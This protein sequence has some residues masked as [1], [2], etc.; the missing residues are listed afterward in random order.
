MNA[1]SRPHTESKNR[2]QDHV[3]VVAAGTRGRARVL[4]L[5][6]ARAGAD[7]A[8]FGAGRGL[9]AVYSHERLPYVDE[10]E[11][12]IAGVEAIGRRCKAFEA[13]LLDAEQLEDAIAKTV[14][15]YGRLD[16]VVAIAGSLVPVPEAN[17]ERE[18]QDEL[19]LAVPGVFPI[20]KSCVDYLSTQGT[21]R[22][23]L[24][25]GGTGISWRVV[26]LTYLFDVEIGGQDIMVNALCPDELREA[27][28][29]PRPLAHMADPAAVPA[30]PDYVPLEDGPRRNAHREFLEA[31]LRLG[32]H[33]QPW[34]HAQEGAADGFVGGQAR[35][36]PFPPIQAD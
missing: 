12:T 17:P 28:I 9:P 31:A 20:V 15:E 34:P 29:L 25:P 5:A 23:I 36:D 3:V 4:A 8:L 27:P 6:F 22:V 16:I 26:G 2:F 1:H 14:V 19:D 32:E 7:I 33:D 24:V 18:W 30:Q 10:L 21:G 13:D 35:R 11:A